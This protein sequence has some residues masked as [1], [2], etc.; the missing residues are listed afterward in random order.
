MKSR[1]FKTFIFCFTLIISIFDLKGEFSI[2]EV[3]ADSITC[4]GGNDGKITITISDG[5]PPY[6]YV[7]H[8]LF[9]HPAT[10]SQT[11][12]STTVTFENLELS[13]L[14]EVVVMDKGGSGTPVS[15]GQRIPIAQPSLLTVNISTSPT[16]ICVN[17]DVQMHGNP[18]GGNG[19]YSHFW[20]GT[21]AVYL[22]NTNIE[23][24]VFN[25]NTPGSYNLIYKVVDFKGCTDSAE[26]N[27]T[28]HD[29]PSVS[30]G[31]SL[32]SQ[33][34]D[35][36]SYTLTGGTPSGGS[37]SG[38]G[39]SGGN[40]NA[41]AS[42]G[43]GTKIIT[44]SYTDGNGCSNSANNTIVVL[45]LPTVTASN[46]GPVCENFQLLLYGSISGTAPFFYQWTG[47]SGFF[48]NL[49]NPEVS[50]NATL[51]MAGTYTFSVMDG[52]SCSNQAT[53]EVSV[54]S[55]PASPTGLSNQ[56][57]C[58][59]GTLS[60]TASAADSNDSIQWSYD[61]VNVVFTSR[62]PSTFTT[63]ILTAPSSITVYARVKSFSGGC[64]SSWVSATGNAYIPTTATS[65]SN[66]PVCEGGTLTLSALPDG[67]SSY[68]WTGPN[69]YSSNTQ[70]PT[71]T[72]NANSLHAGAY[73]LTIIDGNGCSDTK[74]TNVTINPAPTKFNVTGGGS[75]C[76]GG[77][78]V[79]V[80]LSGSQTGVN[81]QLKLNGVN[82]G[83]PVAGT[84]SALNFGM[85]TSAGTYTVEATNTVTSCIGLM[86]N[87]VT[88]TINTPP[89]PTASNN[90]PVCPGN[91]LSLSALPNGMS[92][93]SWTG[94]NGFISN[95]QNP[96][97]SSSATAAMAGTYKLVITDA[98]GCKD[99]TTTIVTIYSK[100]S[101]TVSTNS[102][103]C[104][105]DTLKLFGG[106]SGMTS[107]KWSGP[108]GY[109]SSSQNPFRANAVP[110]FGGIYK[111]VITDGN[112]C[113]D[114]TT[115]SV[116]VYTVPTTSYTLSDP[117]VCYYSD[118]TI[119]LSGS[120]SS[121]QYTIFRESDNTQVT[122]PEIGTGGSLSFTV[123]ASNIPTVGTN[124]FYCLIV[125]PKN[126]PYKVS[127]RAIVTKRAEILKNL[128]S[129]NPLC[130]GQNGTISTSPTNG[131]SPY[132]M[133][134]NGIGGTFGALS[135]SV[136][137]GN[138]VVVVKD[139]NTCLSSPSSVSIT[140]PA[141]LSFNID[142]ASPS[143]SGTNDGYIKFINVTGGV[144]P[145]QYS[146]RGD[147]AG[148]YT[149]NPNFLNLFQDTYY[150]IIKDANSCLTDSII[151]P[152]VS[153][154]QIFV[155][156]S[157]A[158]AQ[159]CYGDSGQ[160]TLT[161]SSGSGNYHYSVS[162]T[163]G[164]PGAWTSNN[165]FNIQGGISY[166]GFARDMVNGCIANAN[167]GNPISISSAPRINIIINS[168]SAPTCSYSSDG[169]ISLGNASGGKGGPYTYY[170]DGISN[171]TRNFLNLT[172]GIHTITVADN[173]G[174]SQDSIVNL[175]APPAIVYDS[176]TRMNLL[177]AN[178]MLGEIHIINPHGGTPPLQ[179]TINTLP[180]SSSHD[181]TGLD[182][183]LYDVKIRDS[184]GC[185]KDTFITLTE[186]APFTLIDSTVV[187][188]TCF[189]M[190][191]GEVGLTATGGTTPYT[192]TLKP[193]GTVAQSNGGYTF[194]GLNKGKY[195][196]EVTDA[197]NCAILSTHDS[198]E[199]IEPG[200]LSI[201]STSYSNISC[202]GI[203]GGEIR[204]YASGGNLPYT[205]TLTSGSNVYNSTNNVFSSLPAGTYNISVADSKGCP[206]ASAAPITIL[207]PAPL[208]WGTVTFTDPTC[209]NYSDGSINA[210]ASGGTGSLQYWTNIAP[211]QPSGLF[212]GLTAG[213]YQVFVKDVNNCQIDTS[214]SLSN[215]SPITII[216]AA[217]DTVCSGNKGS[218]TVNAT[219]GNAPLTYTLTPGPV[220]QPNGN[221]INL[222]AGN[223]TVTVSD[224][225]SC[226]TADTS[227]SVVVST[228]VNIKVAFQNIKCKGDNSGSITIS[229]S[230]GDA[231]YQYSIHGDIPVQYQSTPVF[232]GLSAGN[233]DIYVKDGCGSHGYGT[234]T[235]NQPASSLIIN[236]ITS[237][238]VSGCKGSSTGA[239]II[240]ATGGSGSLFYSIDGGI[241]FQPSNIFT[242]LPALN[243]PVV[244]RDDSLCHKDT[245]V[246]ITEPNLLKIDRV[247]TTM[248]NGSVK[249]TA[250]I[251]VL[252][253]QSG[254]GSLL[255]WINNSTPQASSLFNNLDTGTYMAHVKDANNCQDSMSFIIH[256]TLAMQVTITTKPVSCYGLS[257]GR[258]DTTIKGGVPPYNFT[259]APNITDLTH[260][261][262]NTYSIIITDANSSIYTTSVT[263]SQPT[264]VGATYVITAY[265]GTPGTGSIVVNGTGGNGGYLYSFNNGAFS[266][267]NTFSDLSPG[268][269]RVITKD[270]LGCSGPD[271]TI[272]IADDHILAL[273]PVTHT[274]VSCFGTNSGTATV[275][276]KSGTAPFT[277]R[278]RKGGTLIGTVVTNLKDY[279]FTN[280]SSG[281]YQFNVRHSL[282]G[283][284]VNSETFT[285]SELA[286]SLLTITNI[287]TVAQT[288]VVPN[289]EIHITASGGVGS[290]SSYNFSI[291]GGVSFSMNAG[292]FYGLKGDS[293]YSIAVQ[294]QVG[295]IIH[296]TA[297]VPYGLPLNV[298]FSKTN[299][300]C[301]GLNDG[302]LSYKVISGKKPFYYSF[303]GSPFISAPDSFTFSMLPPGNY[304]LDIADVND[305][306]SFSADINSA[307][308]VLIDSIVTTPA[309]NGNGTL[310]VYTSG[311]SG[312]FTYTATSYHHG[313]FTNG[314]NNI[315]S[316]LPADTFI[317]RVDDKCSN[318]QKIA[319]VPQDTVL[320][321]TVSVDPIKCI[322]PFLQ[323][324]INIKPLNAAPGMITYEAVQSVT[325]DYYIQFNDGNVEVNDS[326]T[327]YI[328]VVDAEGKH[329]RDTVTVTS[330]V[331]PIIV[332]IAPVVQ[333][334]N[335]GGQS[336]IF[337]NATGGLP[338]YTYKWY[339][340]PDYTT[341]ISTDKDLLN[342][343]VGKYL[344]VVTDSFLCSVQA[345][346]SVVTSDV[347]ILK[348]T[349]T[350]SSCNVGKTDGTITVTA[351]GKGT[352]QYIWD[353]G[354][355]TNP[356][357]T[358]VGAGTYTV[359][360]M[361]ESGCSDSR[362]V[363]VAS[364]DSLM[365]LWTYGN[366]TCATEGFIEYFVSRGH[367]N[368]TFIQLGSDTLVS[369]S[370]NYKRDLLPGNYSFKLVDQKGCYDSIN[371]N[372]QPKP[373]FDTIIINSIDIVKS[374][375]ANGQITVHASGLYPPLV[376]KLTS[377]SGIYNINNGPDSVFTG[378]MGGRYYIEVSDH[379]SCA[380]AYDTVDVQLDTVLNV[381]VNI[382]DTACYGAVVSLTPLNAFG[383]VNYQITTDSVNFFINH[384]SDSIFTVSNTGWY[385]IHVVDAVNKSFQKDTFILVAKP[386]LFAIPD[387]IDYPDC[388]TGTTGSIYMRISGGTSPY[389]YSWTNDI[390]GD[391]ISHQQFNLL[392]QS[393][394]Y[395]S[396]NVIDAMGCKFIHRDSIVKSEVKIIKV[397]IVK[398][399]CSILNP[400]GK[401]IITFK[402]RAPFNVTWLNL[403]NLTIVQDGTVSSNIDSIVNVPEGKYLVH[404]VDANNCFSG[405]TTI[406]LQSYNP[407]K[408]SF[409]LLDMPK[410]YSTSDP[411]FDGTISVKMIN[412]KAPYYYNWYL[413]S[414]SSLVRK[415]D[416]IYAL[417]DTLKS[418]SSGGYHVII[419]DSA[420]C[421]FD[422][423]YNVSAKDTVDFDVHVIN[424][425]T[426]STLGNVTI[427]FTKGSSPYYYQWL[428][429]PFDTTYIDS[430]SNNAL[431]AG[432]YPLTLVDDSG[433]IITK[434]VIIKQS[435]YFK[436]DSVITYE[437]CNAY[438]AIA[439]NLSGTAYPAYI[440][441]NNL[442]DTLILH[443]STD[444]IPLLNNLK[445]NLYSVHIWNKIG[446]DT[447]KMFEVK[448]DDSLRID[449]MVKPEDCFNDGSIQV[450]VLNSSYPF[451]Y[452]WIGSG[453]NVLKT[454]N[455]TILLNVTRGTYILATW[456]NDHGCNRIDTFV[457]PFNSPLVVDA[458][459]DTTICR[460]EEY[461]LQGKAYAGGLLGASD[462]LYNWSPVQNLV[463]NKGNIPNPII[464]P[465]IPNSYNINQVDYILNVTLG[466]CYKS[467]TVT[468]SYHPSNGVWL[469]ERDTAVKG[470]YR[471][472]PVIGGTGSYARYLWTPRN[473]VLYNSDT[474][475]ILTINFKADSMTYYFTGITSDGCY[476]KASVLVVATEEVSPDDAFTP[477]G[478]GINDF[479]HIT[480]AEY[481]PDINVKVYN[482]WGNI[483]FETKG[484]NNADKVWN[485]KRKGKD[486]PIGTY[487]YIITMSGG[488]TKKGTVAII[489]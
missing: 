214:L 213:T 100:T 382:K 134:I 118:A 177:C 339:K 204:I 56:K 93:Y 320:L 457:I 102:P 389:N 375:G 486:L 75:Y 82:I 199:V 218:I 142:S 57:R 54:I 301:A 132:T 28:V 350:N 397:D 272:E 104:G 356:V 105:L 436:V 165:V 282:P 60:F 254:A 415:A 477:N 276:I 23:N 40:F 308:P 475:R 128:T 298:Q 64:L 387:S 447:I 269:Y 46:N 473:Y 143:C 89:T 136:S 255:Y 488:H 414:D 55:A 130:F 450:K 435:E 376:Y 108:M 123:L 431:L 190:S 300:T 41:S 445:S 380:F 271:S 34:A 231:P 145:Y 313:I 18:T 309:V 328:H 163:A 423:V 222:V 452:N 113:K 201:D 151:V 245:T 248:V 448:L 73:S 342:V 109:T 351:V 287:S 476:E 147:D 94:P 323:A 80:G 237:I 422:T 83:S 150:A 401:I 306:A 31:G 480:N 466:R 189:G 251:V 373:S 2:E 253:A 79:L 454:D 259:I 44:Y 386:G 336:S 292:A 117:T 343:G 10:Y 444:V 411:T 311:G 345:V 135:Q 438:G 234:V 127:D 469:P 122:D 185:I 32:A 48:S 181:F 158:P 409:T 284:S 479:W 203:G 74:S 371:I 99:S 312:I 86:N 278:L 235:L 256:D 111:L 280:L 337:V 146:I 197:N 249:G 274:D 393:L 20:S 51:G 162:T 67:M 268:F 424:D 153:K 307:S 35:N 229:A 186:P 471:I 161:A 310:T 305:T 352:L 173:G 295:C 474:T 29:L 289:G 364:N 166:Y 468:I 5:E 160:L 426:C 402:G 358:G 481:Y 428:G 141:K 149:S 326:G 226:P 338:P 183:G 429:Q 484:Y 101:A 260:V 232:T 455:D 91:T 180:Y 383:K 346:D 485:G 210:L 244:V 335:A 120:Q 368:Y 121:Y 261:P 378:L 205:Y 381:A 246:V 349:S 399:N 77:S 322:Q 467:D 25:C 460:G 294:D 463:N 195:K 400:T 207:D 263:V 360:V 63:G 70:N 266:S 456:N 416:S 441:W 361:N 392:N 3:V 39:V 125:T 139:A 362:T 369:P 413:A 198:V 372:V 316:G 81:Y 133:S 90:G 170:V 434:P 385:R 325:H 451:M 209:N 114:S 379:T 182:G 437:K 396:F 169:Q 283:P 119:T 47:P 421:Y 293:T 97:V 144:S 228:G 363:T 240:N 403:T 319:V 458:G 281:T 61:G 58:G 33:C 72:N 62:T 22:S 489:R 359:T 78:G 340:M 321:A 442:N 390:S 27:I 154:G 155:G 270:S 206:P 344:V 221:F 470:E 106:P 66:S 212:N 354:V 172:G 478:D 370:D 15:Y 332:N 124:Q 43:P 19:H 384:L 225:K 347:H 388:N 419:R 315:F 366:Q 410:C 84:G 65:S 394:G 21:G 12:D 257:D 167:N 288:Q 297:F 291:D 178:S 69:G 367:P 412:G 377:E 13:N 107:Y 103:V 24:P 439:L 258:I 273:Y 85:Q 211:L 179:Y 187:N 334:C 184:K 188:I 418:A 267:N 314:T 200:V 53:T 425:A 37:Y 59:D 433:C 202:H 299:E 265:N 71:V 96:T 461:I 152:L 168:I 472:I 4:Y 126:C 38:P 217:G 129:S 365:N 115:T 98:N 208:V 279:T 420:Y 49:Q 11:I 264:P 357:I 286:T 327:Y 16:S 333:P 285:I 487:Y 407:L 277:I 50:P 193:T 238:P 459:T 220:I 159:V 236:S 131:T 157:L 219:G 449:T 417:S 88:I 465:F 243:Y 42:G 116:T 406:T 17:A 446:C 241:N 355:S 224:S 329:F 432:N 6:L 112:G 302:T 483:I 110:S 250:N 164:V 1:L 192:Y 443:S 7:L 76:T 156:H 391:T 176:I 303:N 92:S 247:N 318:A 9:P 26:I 137:A 45:A 174:C 36:T 191:N 68:S 14:Y 230:G 464:K 227:L 216:F 430:V 453:V 348:I 374:N 175:P 242:S 395:Y 440:K 138:Y 148:E 331:T 405:D 290:M 215:P 223:Y 462:A 87:S 482:R 296:D 398:P 239:I 95:T 262:A 404:I 304:T 275:H 30:F 330:I 317:V 353:N 252:P 194:T 52:N 8:R 233:Y 427:K 171:G 140:Q 408:G 324:F 341:V 196:I